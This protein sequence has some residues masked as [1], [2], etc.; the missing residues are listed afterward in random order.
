MDFVTLI[1]DRVFTMIDI[2]YFSMYP[3]ALFLT[4]LGLV[5]GSSLF[6]FGFITLFCLVVFSPLMVAEE[7]WRYYKEIGLADENGS[8]SNE[9]VADMIRRGYIFK[10]DRIIDKNGNLIKVTY[11][12]KNHNYTIQTDKADQQKA[13]AY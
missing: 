5:R 12:S 4:Y 7:N 2:V 9:V 8:V 1:G 13:A 6:F 10:R 3:V 11:D